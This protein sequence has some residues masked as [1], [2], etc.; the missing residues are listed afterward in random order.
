MKK[1]VS[2]DIFEE[3]K[4][5]KRGLKSMML[6]NDNYDDSNTSRLDL[7]LLSVIFIPLIILFLIYIN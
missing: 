6:N 1:I 4:A 2:D 7:L 5:P 3:D